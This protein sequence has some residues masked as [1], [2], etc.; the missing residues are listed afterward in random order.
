[1]YIDNLGYNW[2]YNCMI[3]KYANK[4]ICFVNIQNKQIT[5]GSPTLWI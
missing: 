5:G 2:N 3:D 1:M 4:Q